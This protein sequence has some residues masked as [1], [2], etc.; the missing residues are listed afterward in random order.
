M[1]SEEFRL[2]ALF[3]DYQAVALSAEIY[4]VW[5]GL[6]EAR[7][8]GEIAE[9]QVETNASVLDQIKARFGNGQVRRVDIL[10]QKHLLE[11]SRERWIQSE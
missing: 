2:D 4:C 11:A 7:R 10:H 1:D 6:A 9:E 5:Y 3:Y 8:Q